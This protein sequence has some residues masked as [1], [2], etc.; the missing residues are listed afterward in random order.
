MKKLMFIG[1]ILWVTS[2]CWPTQ[3]GFKDTGGMN[4]A[5]KA[6]VVQNLTIQAATCP[7][8]YAPQLTEAIKDGIQNN[9][10]LTLATQAAD[11][12]VLISGEITSYEVNPIAIQNGDNAAKNRLQ[13]SVEFT[14]TTTSP[15]TE[16]SRLT[17]S[18]FA[19]FN[20]NEN[21]AS[22][23]SGLLSSIN[24]QIV[25]DILNKLMSNW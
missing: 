3:V 20:A 6:F 11:A 4:E 24:E 12:Q 22:V 23:E 18:R 16:E 10:R 7:N 21:L 14:I 17:I 1:G 2:A 19:D 5:W 13:V 9:S 15:K 8:S 25:Q